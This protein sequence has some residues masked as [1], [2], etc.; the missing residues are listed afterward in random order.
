MA[1][2][3]PSRGLFVLPSPRGR[4]AG[5]EG[6]SRAGRDDKAGNTPSLCP[7]AQ[8]GI[9]PANPRFPVFVKNRLDF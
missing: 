1:L 3:Q 5:G 2:V 6:E 7:P 8:P 4:G 9:I